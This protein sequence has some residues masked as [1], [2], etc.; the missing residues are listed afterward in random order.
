MSSEPKWLEGISGLDDLD[1]GLRREKDELRP[2]ESLPDGS[3][4][5]TLCEFWVTSHQDSRQQTMSP[6]TAERAAAF[7]QAA[8]WA[9]RLSIANQF[10]AL[11]RQL[12]ERGTGDLEAIQLTESMLRGQAIL[13]GTSNA[14]AETAVEELTTAFYADFSE[15]SASSGSSAS[16]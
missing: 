3:A 7:Y 14:L 11:H 12:T 10:I 6:G 4:R 8:G 15:P 13:G 1:K 16:D 9:R 5:H 2:L